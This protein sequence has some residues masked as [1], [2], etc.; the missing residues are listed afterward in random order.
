MV[1]KDINVKNVNMS[2]P[3]THIRLQCIQKLKEACFTKLY[4]IR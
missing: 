3:I 1:N 4:W 2:L